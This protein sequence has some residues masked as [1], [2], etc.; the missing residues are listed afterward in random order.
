MT[1]FSINWQGAMLGIDSKFMNA[2][3]Y[4]EYS[5]KELTQDLKVDFYLF[6]QCKQ[7]YENL[8]ETP[9]LYENV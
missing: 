7:I 6:N 5:K 2:R 8:N 4:R 9:L 3:G 1:E